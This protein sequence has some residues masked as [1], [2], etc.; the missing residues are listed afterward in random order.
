VGGR[1]KEPSPIRGGLLPGAKTG[2]SQKPTWP[3]YWRQKTA[4]EADTDRS[5]LA[6]RTALLG[7]HLGHWLTAD[8]PSP[9]YVKTD[10]DIHLSSG[11]RSR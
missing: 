2:L 5:A 10:I 4:F 6:A 9:V 8:G 7:P 1:R 11:C 3:D